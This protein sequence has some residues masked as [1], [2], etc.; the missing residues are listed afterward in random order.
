M[1][2]R[3]QSGITQEW[4]LDQFD[5]W[6]ERLNSKNI[7]PI[8]RAMRDTSPVV[9]SRAQGGIWCITRYED[10][11]NIARDFKTFS[12]RNV[13]DI[14]NANRGPENRVR[15]LI[16]LDPP[17][18]TVHRKVMQVP[19]LASK[20]GE[21][22]DGIRVSVREL[23]E[24]ISLMK[25]FD[26]V[27]DLAEPVPQEVLAKVLGFDDVSRKRNR[28]LVLNFVTA[29]LETRASKQAE[30]REF[31]LE[32]VR[33][34]I[35]N[36]GDDYLSQMCLAEH[37]GER[38]SESELV[39]MVMG[40]ALAGH[41]T[42]INAI[43]SMLWRLSNYDVKEMYLSNPEIGAKI[44]E[45]TL[46]C[47]PPIHLEGR[48]TTS[49]VVVGGVVIPEGE[50]IALIY[51]SANYDERQ[52]E[53]PESFNPQRSSLQHLAFGH[54]I[55]TCIG[56][57]LARLEMN[58]ILEEIMNWFPNYTLTREPVETGMVFGHHFGWHSMPAS[59]SR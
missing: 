49:E 11:R 50:S 17:E 53:N 29:N 14:G 35:A 27:E 40:F 44:V 28:E 15:R 36:P 30:F 52:F 48:T 20:V 22:S 1:T 4:G 57:N 16:E 55:H 34:K 39:G 12:S 18:H 54:G 6:D 25:D 26:I 3:Y 51:A 9:Y 58:I 10:V 31:L 33:E 42:S 38:F 19:F 5:P 24:K 59:I 32:K 37:D 13:L 43:A 45:E 7:W 21:F 8:Y 41:H 56:M 47:D 46:R 23:L 2:S